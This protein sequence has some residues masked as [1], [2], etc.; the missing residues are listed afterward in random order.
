MNPALLRAFKSL[1]CE[2]AG[3]FLDSYFHQLSFPSKL[4]KFLWK[5]FQITLDGFAYVGEGL[6]SV[7]SLADASWKVDNLGRVA[8]CFFSED[9]REL[10]VFYFNYVD[11]AVV[12]VC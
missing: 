8:F 10:Q 12:I 11:H 9:Y 6:F 2:S 4:V 7:F 5:R 3:N 1:W